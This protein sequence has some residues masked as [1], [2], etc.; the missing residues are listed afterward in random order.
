VVLVAIEPADRSAER[1][2]AR[3]NGSRERGS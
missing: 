2:E 1:D 3:T